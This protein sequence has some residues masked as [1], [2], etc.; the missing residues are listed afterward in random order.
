M[1]TIVQY[2]LGVSV[3]ILFQ[4]CKTSDDN[5][6]GEPYAKNHYIQF[7]MSDLKEDGI[8]IEKYLKANLIIDEEQKTINIEKENDSMQ[9]HYMS[10]VLRFQN[11]YSRGSVQGQVNRYEEYAELINDNHYPLSIYNSWLYA[12]P[13]AIVDTF[14]SVKIF[15]DED[16]I[17]DFPAG[18]DVSSLFNIYFEDPL[19]TIQ[20][21]YQSVTAADTYQDKRMGSFPHTITGNVLSEI[22]FS[23]KNFI[24]GQWLL[25]PNQKPDILGE[26]TFTIEITTNNGR[27]I[28][29]ITEPFM[30]N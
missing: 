26:Y 22:D 7:F 21:N 23:Q 2:I 14:Q 19:L 12:F 10:V 9:N 18:S 29:K 25:M 28:T 15:T 6:C 13:T 1:K 17:A 27:V 16:Y 30:I 11:I 4:N 20:N 3:L 24:G 5:C 8:F